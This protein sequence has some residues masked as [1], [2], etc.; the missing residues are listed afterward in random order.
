MSEV[1][2]DEE[3]LTGEVVVGPNEV[4][5]LALSPFNGQRIPDDAKVFINWKTSEGAKGADIGTLTPNGPEGTGVLDAPG[6]YLIERTDGE[7]LVERSD[8]P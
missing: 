3:T 2:L 8:A 7:F 1:L 5:T 6:T 4:V